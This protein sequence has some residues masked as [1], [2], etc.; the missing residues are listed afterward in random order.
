MSV[1]VHL[2]AFICLKS[3]RRI[4]RSLIKYTAE[5]EKYALNDKSNV[6]EKILEI[7]C[8]YG[9]KIDEINAKKSASLDCVQGGGYK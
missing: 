9:V 7:Y 4:E 3:C 5:R 6:S 1:S 8:T 2:A